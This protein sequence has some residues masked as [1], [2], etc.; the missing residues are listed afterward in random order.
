MKL[1]NVPHLYCPAC[2]HT[3]FAGAT[4]VMSSA[5]VVASVEATV[6]ALV[7]TL[8]LVVMG[9]TDVMSESMVVAHQATET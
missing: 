9:R 2:V 6:G 1:Q 3:S 4:V 8:G 5:V 7:M